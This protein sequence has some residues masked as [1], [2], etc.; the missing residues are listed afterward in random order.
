MTRRKVTMRRAVAGALASVSIFAGMAFASPQAASAACSTSTGA[1]IFYYQVADC[2]SS[3]YLGKINTDAEI[4]YLSNY[5][6]G[7]NNTMSAVNE[8][9]KTSQGSWRLYLFDGSDL[10]GAVL[11]LSNGSTSTSKS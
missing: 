10:Q 8:S 11:G 7:W 5:G 1:G 6:V 3:S 4:H 9:P 2:A